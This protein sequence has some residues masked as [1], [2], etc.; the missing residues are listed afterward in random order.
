M[1]SKIYRA[2]DKFAYNIFVLSHDVHRISFKYSLVSLK[3]DFLFPGVF[4]V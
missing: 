3:Q 2:R 1:S 4:E